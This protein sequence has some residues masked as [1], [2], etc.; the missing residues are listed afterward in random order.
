M[1]VPDPGPERPPERGTGPER[2][3]ERATAP[4]RDVDGEG[5][6]IRVN[7]Q[8]EIRRELEHVFDFLSDGERLPAWM[9]GVKR[10]KRTSPG[11]PTGT[12]TTYRLV[13]KALGRRVE[14]SYEL[15]AYDPMQAFS[16]RM[17]SR[18]FCLEQTYRFEDADG[19]TK[20]ALSGRAVPL[21]RFKLLG[22]FLFLAM[23]RQVRSDHRRLKG[24]LERSRGPAHTGLRRP[25]AAA[26]GG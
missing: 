13:G 10:A 21:G 23:Q 11:G 7:D 14:S 20:V 18:Y 16:A 9:A 12:G 5:P 8:L 4:E 26:T 3:P 22:P 19:A 24:V 17:E 1:A 6:G 25:G 15:T 2:P